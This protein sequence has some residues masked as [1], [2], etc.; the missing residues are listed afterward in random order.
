MGRAH[1]TDLVGAE[2]LALLPL[3]SARL[4]RPEGASDVSVL[5]LGAG[6]VLRPR[7]GRPWL[8][9]ASAGASV[10]RYHVAGVPS[11][12]VEPVTG[13]TWSA[14]AQARLGAGVAV[15]RWL[16]AR[17]DGVAGVTAR[18][19]VVS[20]LDASQVSHDAGSWG[21][22]FVAASLGLEAAF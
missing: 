10:V 19:L 12:G 14:A 22:L 17:A 4:T 7:L 6:A 9:D 21:H 11:A 20:T 16:A 2:V 13:D 1:L 8:A 15:T 18:R 3:A 5:V